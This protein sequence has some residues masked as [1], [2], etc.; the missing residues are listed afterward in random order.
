MRTFVLILLC[1]TFAS[2]NNNAS[3]AKEAVKDSI[4]KAE[5]NTVD[6][7]LKNQD[8]ILKEKEKE[9]LEKYN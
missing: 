2:C 5:L 9:L 7:M 3:K 6:D 1:G 4:E 8:S